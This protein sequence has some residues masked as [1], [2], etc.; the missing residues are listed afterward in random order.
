MTRP[1]TDLLLSEPL[2][3]ERRDSD[4]RR[5]DWHTNDRRQNFPWVVDINDRRS[6]FDRR[7]E[8]RR[9]QT[10]QRAWASTA[11]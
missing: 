1:C 5:S 9:G 6:G 7:W 2:S 4:R 8:Q 10:G 11:N 3:Q